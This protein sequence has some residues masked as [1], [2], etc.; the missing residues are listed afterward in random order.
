MPEFL[1]AL[2]AIVATFIVGLHGKPATVPVNHADVATRGEVVSQTATTM[3]THKS[4]VANTTTAAT[5][6]EVSNESD[7]EKSDSADNDDNSTK[8]DTTKVAATNTSSGKTMPALIPV[9]ALE[10][11]GSLEAATSTET[12][13]NTSVKAE[14]KADLN[15]HATFGQGI[16]ISQPDSAKTNGKVFGQTTA[17]AAKDNG[18]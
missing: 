5:S 16:A 11:S 4:S 1:Q 13:E 7:E 17:Q 3:D 12:E 10:H 15:A 9:V 8:P 2:M 18:R 14:V 6:D